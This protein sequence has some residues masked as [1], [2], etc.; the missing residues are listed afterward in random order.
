MNYKYDKTL[1]LKDDNMIYLYSNRKELFNT[2]NPHLAK[3]DKFLLF[4]NISVL[5]NYYG[6]F[7][8]KNGIQGFNKDGI[9]DTIKV[10]ESCDYNIRMLNLAYNYNF[11]SIKFCSKKYRY[12]INAGRFIFSIYNKGKVQVNVYDGFS[13]DE[14]ENP[15]TINW[16]EW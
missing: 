3:K 9:L 14:C 11:D 12:P 8:T 7:Y 6:C 16:E 4:E 13:F 10:T 5:G 15:K 2:I 1:K